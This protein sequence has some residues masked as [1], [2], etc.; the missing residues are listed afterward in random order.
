VRYTIDDTALT[1]QVGVEERH[2]GYDTAA[3]RVFDATGDGESVLAVCNTIE[4]SKKLTNQ[5]TGR[6]GVVHLGEVIETV[7]QERDIDASD[8][9]MTATAIANKVPHG[10]RRFR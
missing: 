10:R 3:D 2:L 1:R 7:L 9:S 6:P 4:S 5:V 8:P